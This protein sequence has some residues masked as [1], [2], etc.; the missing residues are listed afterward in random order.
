M[1]PSPGYKFPTTGNRNLK[2]QYDWLLQY[3]WLCFSQTYNGTYCKVCVFFF[4]HNQGIGKGTHQNVEKLVS[5]KFDNWKKTLGLKGVFETHAKTEYHKSSQYR[6]DTF[7]AVKSNKVESFEIQVNSALRKEIKSVL[8][9]L[10]KLCYFVEDRV[11]LCVVIR[12]VDWLVVMKVKFA[13]MVI[14]L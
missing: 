9:R 6:F 1:S 8:F 12:I 3:K 2:F 11:L 4:G 10:L 13:M 5:E 14:P 7:L